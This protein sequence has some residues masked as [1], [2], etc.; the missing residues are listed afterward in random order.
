M[1]SKGEILKAMNALMRQV[2]FVQKEKN[3]NLKYESVS[4][5][6][7]LEIIRSKALD[8]G[9]CMIPS[10]CQHT[11]CTP[12]ERAGYDNK[13]IN[14]KCDSYV[15]T[16][17]I[18]HISG[19]YLIVKAPAIGVDEQ[20]KG[21]GKAITYATKNAWLKALML[22]TGDDPEN[23]QQQSYQNQQRP[24]QQNRD[25]QPYQQNNQPQQNRQQ[26]QQQAQQRQGGTLT[27]EPITWPVDWQN[28]LKQGTA[29]AK[30]FNKI[31][32]DPDFDFMGL[33]RA[34]KQSIDAKNPPPVIVNTIMHQVA[35]W[36][37]DTAMKTVNAQKTQVAVLE[38]WPEF[39]SYIG[40]GEKANKIKSVLENFVPW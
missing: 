16:F 1:E 30:D 33:L 23:S 34:S 10:D 19:E 3:P 29:A 27:A 20:D 9:L 6:G 38:N 31:N 40:P 35:G 4:Y 37:I 25:R 15:F 28:V 39:E 13:T 5:D 26:P 12:Y 24:Q 11:N 7:L 8:N 22:K 14:M 17:T 36:L 18:W 2:E 32:D 21:P